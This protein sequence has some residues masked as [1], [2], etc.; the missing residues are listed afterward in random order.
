MSVI[1]LPHN[2]VIPNSLY[3]SLA[4]PVLPVLT[5][6]Y[7]EVNKLLGGFTFYLVAM[8]LTLSFLILKMDRKWISKRAVKIRDDKW[9]EAELQTGT[10]CKCQEAFVPGGSLL[11]AIITRRPWNLVDHN[12]T[13]PGQALPKTLPVKPWRKL[14]FEP[15]EIGDILKISRGLFCFEKAIS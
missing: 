11:Q 5:I 4:I 14:L 3:S 12:P 6:N 2:L 8:C 15:L 10:Q 13:L 1:P 7:S 9:K